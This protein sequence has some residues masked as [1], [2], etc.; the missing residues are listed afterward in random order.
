MH[1]QA[2]VGA[3]DSLYGTSKYT[4]AIDHYLESM[5]LSENNPERFTAFESI[6]MKKK[7]LL[8]LT[9]KM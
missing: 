5:K 1:Y 2:L 7:C 6:Y 8:K 9:I 4:E 3:A